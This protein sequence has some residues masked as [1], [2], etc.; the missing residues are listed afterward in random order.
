MPLQN[1][2][3]ILLQRW[4]SWGVPMF[5]TSPYLG[6]LNAPPA[7]TACFQKLIGQPWPH[8]GCIPK[9]TH[10][11]ESLVR[12]G[13]SLNCP[14]IVSLSSPSTWPSWSLQLLIN[15][16]SESQTYLPCTLL[17]TLLNCLH[18]DR[19]QPAWKSRQWMAAVIPMQCEKHPG[20]SGCWHPPVMDPRALCIEALQERA[21]MTA[22]A[23]LV[24]QMCSSGLWA[25]KGGIRLARHLATTTN[26]VYKKGEYRFSP[27]LERHLPFRPLATTTHELSPF[28]DTQIFSGPTSHS[29]GAGNRRLGQTGLG[30]HCSLLTGKACTVTG[31]LPSWRMISFQWQT[32]PEIAYYFSGKFQRGKAHAELS[33][34]SWSV[35]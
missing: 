1:P 18:H 25:G 5:I 31:W 11:H 30:G 29:E 21:S 3:N 14:W 26:G 13:T 10:T 15:P 8:H 35:R 4:K 2:K 27:C 16:R 6:A 19:P 12:W 22:W 24:H 33:V 17:A 32:S 9:G 28:K 34:G 23:T 7:Q 20:R